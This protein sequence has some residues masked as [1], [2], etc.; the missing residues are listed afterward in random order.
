MNGKKTNLEL[1]E[2]LSLLQSYFDIFYFYAKE[3]MIKMYSVFKA[4]CSGCQNS[5]LSQMDFWSVTNGPCLFNV[6][7]G[8]AGP[9][10]I[11]FHYACL[12]GGQRIDPVS[13]VS[14]F[15]L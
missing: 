4:K 3:I 10:S 13:P 12:C 9:V 14:S 7:P 15:T 11:R 6:N 8:P 2:S 1:S 5:R